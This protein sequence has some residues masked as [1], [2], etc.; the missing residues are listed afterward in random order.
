MTLYGKGYFIWQ[1]PRAE[2]GDAAAITAVAQEARLSHVLLKI[3]DGPTWAYNYD[4]ER[5]VDL[6]PPVRDALRAGGIQV[7]AWHYVRGDDPV[8]EARLAVRRTKELELDG[9]VIDA[10][11]EYKKP[12]RKIAAQR[13]MQELRSGLPSLPVALSSY[14]FPRSHPDL[15]YEIFMEQSDYAMP[16]VYFEQAHNPEQQLERTVEQYMGLTNAR[17][18]IPT[19][20]T[21]GRGDW[22]PTVEEVTRFFAKAK[23]LGLT[24]A[25]AWSWDFARRPEHQEL[26]EAVAQFDWPAEAP[27]ADL[28]ERLVG[29]MNQGDPAH[30]AAL[31]HDN[32]AH[33]TGAR[34]ILGREPIQEWYQTMFGQLLPGGQFEMTGKSGVGHSRHFTWKATSGAGAVIDGNDTLG[35]RDG[36]IQYHYTF[37]TVT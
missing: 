7:W 25:N 5:Q 13:F 11:A 31:Y 30:V 24:A 37:F 12:G 23:E 17:P 3:A 34:T 4:H 22:K 2:G 6:I 27:I 35:I 19:A 21:Y 28:P 20:P 18:V 15:P 16:Q 10:E 32:A 26:W 1:I 9:Y 14:R 36:L 33:V 8:S 29:R